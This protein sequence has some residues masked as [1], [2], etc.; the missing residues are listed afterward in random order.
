M[1]LFNEGWDRSSEGDHA[2]MPLE[3]V[4]ATLILIVLAYV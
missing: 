3:K 1:P 2:R 4:A